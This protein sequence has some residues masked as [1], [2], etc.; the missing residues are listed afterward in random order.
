MATTQGPTTTVVTGG[1][2]AAPAI[3]TSRLAQMQMRFQQRQQQE[4]DQR[5]VDM[6]STGTRTA[7]T[8]SSTITGGNG[9]S[10]LTTATTVLRSTTV[11]HSS[12]VG[13]EPAADLSATLGAGKVRQM[14]DERRAHRGAGIDKSYPLQPIQPKVVASSN[15]TN[16]NNNS[17]AN[18]NATKSGTAAAGMNN[19]TRVPPISASTKARLAV[20]ARQQEDNGNEEVSKNVSFDDNENLLDDEKF[21]DTISFEDDAALATHATISGNHS[22]N[23]KLQN[24]GKTS[25]VSQPNVNSLKLKPVPGRAPAAVGIKP[26]SAT[27]SVSKKSVATAPAAAPLSSPSTTTTTAGLRG[28]QPSSAKSTTT[29]RASTP[30]KSAMALARRKPSTASSVMSTTGISTLSAAG[31]SIDGGPTPAGLTRCSIC[32]RNFADER[33]EKHREICMKTKSKKRKV[34]DTTK[35]RVA[36]TEAE[37]YINK[38]KPGTTGGGGGGGKKSITGTT[39]AAAGRK[40]DWRRKHEEFIQAI[41]AA[42][43]MQAHLARG[44]KLSD[45]PPPPPSENPDY[46]Q[47]PHCSRR[48]NQTAAE[49]HIPKCATMLHNKPKPNQPKGKRF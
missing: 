5:K 17:V 26:V 20:Q 49:R 31:F 36:G 30:G 27:K 9:N 12:P 24:V 10:S 41:R 38:K 47:C 8:S 44:G 37:K 40:S 21:P 34:F 45:L 6:I 28:S 11:S 33:I 39:A 4:R 7:V 43:E 19:K 42:K 3:M 32:N 1:V 22:V 25:V 16:N 48:F 23:R 15:H 35:Q 2:A 14:F 46:V 13:S 29:S 18:G